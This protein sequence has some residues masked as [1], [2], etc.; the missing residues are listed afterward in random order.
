MLASRLLDSYPEIRV[1]PPPDRPP[2][3]SRN[4][5]WFIDDEVHGNEDEVHRIDGCLMQGFDV[6]SELHAGL[7][8]FPCDRLDSIRGGLP[9][10]GSGH[11]A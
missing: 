4:K 7:C 9:C 11:L 1:S 8:P 6:I 2:D 10:E 5:N 3:G